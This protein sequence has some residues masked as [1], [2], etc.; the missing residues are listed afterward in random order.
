MLNIVKTKEEEEIAPQGRFFFKF[1]VASDRDFAFGNTHS[2]CMP[3]E[4]IAGHTNW[5][6]HVG[7]NRKHTHTHTSTTPIF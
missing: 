6:C 2:D 7:T 3:G 1:Y 5:G 4:A